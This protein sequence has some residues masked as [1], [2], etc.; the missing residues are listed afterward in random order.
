MRAI[1]AQ[2]LVIDLTITAGSACLADQ[3]TDTPTLED[4]LVDGHFRIADAKAI[5]NRGDPIASY[6]Q[7]F[8]LSEQ[9]IH[10]FLAAGRRIEAR[11]FHDND[12]YSAAPCAMRGHLSRGGNIDEFEVMASG[13][14]RVWRADE[15]VILECVKRCEQLLLEGTASEPSR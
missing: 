2:G 13:I 3:P 12:D 11:A 6:C 8:R 15:N 1:G 14:A 10:Q 7:D 5:I 9:Q 4:D